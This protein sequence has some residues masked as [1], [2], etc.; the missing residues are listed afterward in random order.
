[1]TAT[2]T[3]RSASAASMSLSRGHVEIL[4][5]LRDRTSVI[6]TFL[7]PAM[8]LLL[9]GTIFGDSYEGTGVTASQVYTASMLAYGA[10]TTGFVTMG[11]GLAMDREDGTLKR[12]RGT[13]LPMVSY[14]AGKLLLVFV[15]AVAEAALLLLVGWLVFDMPM[16]DASHWLTFAWVF[17]LSVTVCTLLGIAVSGIVKH[18]RNAGAILNVPVVFLQ[19]ISGV[20]ITP[21][22]VLP[23]WL[24]TV[25]SL[26]PI[27][28]MA[29]GF[30]YVFLPDSMKQFEA[31]GS[32]EL[33]RIAMVLGAWCVIG[34]VLCLTTFRWSDKDR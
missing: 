2:T 4:Q 15:L 17:V 1:M 14:L 9:F 20:F 26:F 23:S 18:A 10:L 32:W 22:T 28:W 7:F 31:A 27:K 8:L 25:A 5:F 11:A 13:P 16:P 24:I 34:L 6:F 19:F 29:Q 12:L 30:R 21:I 33:G 3:A